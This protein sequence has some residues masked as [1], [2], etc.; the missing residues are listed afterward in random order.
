ML[1]VLAIA[2]SPLSQVTAMFNI[3]GLPFPLTTATFISSF[4]VVVCLYAVVYC[5]VVRWSGTV[6]PLVRTYNSHLKPFFDLALIRAR[7]ALE[8]AMALSSTKEH[9]VAELPVSEEDAPTFS[10]HL[11]APIYPPQRAMTWPVVSSLTWS[12][13]R[14]QSEE[15]EL[16]GINV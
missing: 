4:V 10:T 11:P 16:P 5:V 12:W 8:A 6:K 1:A 13:R 14:D 9:V 3:Q 2:F 7:G 15:Y